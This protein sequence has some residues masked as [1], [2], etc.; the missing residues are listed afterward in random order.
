MSRRVVC[1]LVVSAVV[2]VGVFLAPVVS[3]YL[4][5]FYPDSH[6]DM[7]DGQPVCAG[8]GAGCYEYVSGNKH[9]TDWGGERYCKQFDVRPY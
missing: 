6:P 5:H 4:L 7:I 9:C 3:A 2:T 1:A 8:S